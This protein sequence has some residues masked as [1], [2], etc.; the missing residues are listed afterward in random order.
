LLNY[1][2]SDIFSPSIL[3]APCLIILFESEV[4]DVKPASFN[5]SAIAY[6]LS[7]AVNSTSLISSGIA[8]RLNCASKSS[9]AFTA[10]A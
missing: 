1:L 4:P 5:S 8:P 6:P 9:N 3:T 2:L 10:A 7:I